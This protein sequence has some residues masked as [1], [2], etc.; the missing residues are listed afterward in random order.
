MLL[1]ERGLN[2]SGIALIV[3]ALALLCIALLT[4]QWCEALP[5]H[6][7][8]VTIAPEVNYAAP[9]VSKLDE[10]TFRGN[11][12]IEKPQGVER[13]TVTLSA[14]CNRG[15]P[16]TIS[17][18][19][20]PFINPGTERFSLKVIVPP[21]TQV[22]E[23]GVTVTARA[24]SPI[25]D[26]EQQ[27]SC[28]VVVLQYFKMDILSYSPT[29]DG[30]AGGSVAGSIVIN[31]SGNDE[32]TFSIDIVKLPKEIKSVTLSQEAI[33]IPFGFYDEIDFTLFISED[34]GSIMD[35]KVITILFEVTSLGAKEEGKQYFKTYP[36]YIHFTGL[37]EKFFDNWTLYVTYGVVAGLVIAVPAI[38]IRRRR[39]RRDEAVL[40]EADAGTE[41]G[42][43]H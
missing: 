34:I 16:T 18:Q 20:I 27:A 15:W 32:D 30:K 23:A 11:V 21:A 8:Q 39:R 36:V 6:S 3:G 19:T 25:W 24:H 26:D 17:P 9:T 10:V 4:S 2:S 28:R 5:G 38:L 41:N 14:S 31:N 40:E 29:Q 37:E 35:S 43:P 1:P 7:M 12:T 22:M 13:V 42:T 33:T